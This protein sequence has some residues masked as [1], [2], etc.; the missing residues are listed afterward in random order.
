MHPDHKIYT[1]TSGSFGCGAVWA[2]R[3]FQFEWLQEYATVPIASKEFLPI[4]MA[5]LVWGCAWQG[6][7]VHM[8]TDNEVVVAVVNSGYSKDPQIMHLVRC[9]FFVLAAGDISL[10]SHHIAGVLNTVA[11]AISRNNIRLLFS[12]VPGADPTPT[13]IPAELVELLVTSQPDWTLPS[14]GHLFRSC[15]QQV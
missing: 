13:K 10:Y 11:D 12:K 7:V 1:D 4:V 3:W 14:W 6:K 2:Q 8:H 9:L 15:L 5:C